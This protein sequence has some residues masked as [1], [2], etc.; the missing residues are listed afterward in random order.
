MY[1]KDKNLM[2]VKSIKVLAYSGYKVFEVPRAFF[3]DDEKIEIKELLS[4]WQEG[5]IDPKVYVKR[6]FK[7]KGNDGYEYTIYYD[8]GLKEWFLV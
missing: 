5:S 1:R 3:I 6:Y 7:V 2:K 8:E 4:S